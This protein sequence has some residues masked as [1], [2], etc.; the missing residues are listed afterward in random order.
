MIRIP[1]GSAPDFKNK[2]WTIAA[3]V[4][5]P[6]GGANGVL[7][8]I[9]GRYG[10]WALLVQ[11]GKPLFAY[12]YSN[13]PEHKFRVASDQSL[14]TCNHIVRIKF[15]YDGGGI[16]KSATA[17]LLVDEKQVAQGRIPETIGVRFSLDETFDIAEDTGTPVLEE[18]ADKMPFRFTGTL[19]KF[20]TVL[21]PSTLSADEQRR[22]H[23]ELAKAMM[24]VQ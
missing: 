4:T 18:Y 23:D 11:D 19:K 20:G 13:Q 9:G 21:E 6:E 3:D 17:T 24:A 12:A 1:E 2:S 10:G 14:A 15:E 16:G 7:A 22:L 8:T 5:V